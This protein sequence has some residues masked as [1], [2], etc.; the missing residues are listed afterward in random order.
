MA[1]AEKVNSIEELEEKLAGHC[2]GTDGY[3]QVNPFVRSFLVTDGVKHFAELAG[4][5]WLLDEIALHLKEMFKTDNTFLVVRVT[6]NKKQ[7]GSSNADIKVYEGYN[8]EETEE[9]ND[10]NYLVYKKHIGYTDLVNG[11]HKFYLQRQAGMVICL[12]PIE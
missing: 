6:S 3:H 4:A 2:I 8:S 10:K 9:E 7:N 5:Y 11:T 12:L 1:V